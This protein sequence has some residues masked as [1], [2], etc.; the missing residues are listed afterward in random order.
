MIVLAR[1]T[2]VKNLV[3]RWTTLT[4]L[5][6]FGNRRIGEHD[7]HKKP[8]FSSLG[9]TPS[10]Q[11]HFGMYVEIVGFPVPSSAGDNSNQPLF[12]LPPPTTSKR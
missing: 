4:S 2:D 12:H 6:F 5:L 10:R 8:F 11:R 3:Q 1:T 9:S 7:F